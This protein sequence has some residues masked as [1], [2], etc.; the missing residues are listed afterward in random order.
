MLKVP[1]IDVSKLITPFVLTLHLAN[2]EDRSSSAAK[3]DKISV[4]HLFGEAPYVGNLARM[5]IL[6]Y[7]VC[8]LRP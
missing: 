8:T 7:G 1:S 3:D 5:T 6:T 2:A 4:F